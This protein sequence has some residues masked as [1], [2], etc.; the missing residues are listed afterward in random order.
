M[1]QAQVVITL[2]YF[3]YLFSTATFTEMDLV[4]GSHDLDID[5]ARQAKLAIREGVT[6]W[7]ERKIWRKRKEAGILAAI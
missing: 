5:T 7:K 4:Q 3:Q 2:G 1:T 6:K